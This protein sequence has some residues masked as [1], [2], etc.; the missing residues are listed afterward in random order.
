MSYETPLH[1]KQGFHKSMQWRDS[2]KSTPCG[3]NG[4]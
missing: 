4:A 3:K 2:G 1:E